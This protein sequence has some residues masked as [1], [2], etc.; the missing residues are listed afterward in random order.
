MVYKTEPA[1]KIQTKIAATR[2]L[3][4][5]HLRKGKNRGKLLLW[6]GFVNN[7]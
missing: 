4:S 6:V 2:T 5:S 1:Y 7:S 3:P